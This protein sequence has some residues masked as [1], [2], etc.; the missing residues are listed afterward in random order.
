MKVSHGMNPRP[1]AGVVSRGR[2]EQGFSL[3]ELV[4]V[5]VLISALAVAA[6]PRLASNSGIDEAVFHQELLNALRYA[7][8]LAVNSGCDVQVDIRAA[9]NTY[10]LYFRDDAGAVSCGGAGGF[11]AFPVPNP[12]GSGAYAGSAPDGVNI[13]GD[14]VFFFDARGRP[15]NGGGGVNLNT[16]SLRVEGVSGY[17]H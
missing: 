17:V 1:G 8:K 14:L 9:G 15:S 10:A 6:Y 13:A 16:K 3:I 12:S 5:I 4:A 2:A 11:G 7:H